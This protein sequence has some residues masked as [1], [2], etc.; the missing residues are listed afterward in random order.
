MPRFMEKS[1]KAAAN[2]KLAHKAQHKI[3]IASKAQ[4]KKMS[5]KKQDDDEDEGL[6]HEGWLR[7]ASIHFSSAEAHPSIPMGQNAAGEDEEYKIDVIFGNHNVDANGEEEDNPCVDDEEVDM[8]SVFRR[9]DS[10]GEEDQT[11]EPVP[12]PDAFYFRLSNNN[13][14]YAENDVS[15]VVL[16]AI[17]IENVIQT[18]DSEVDLSQCFSIVN[19]END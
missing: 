14:Y 19:E 10:Y 17:A 13:L 4:H 6:K 1:G 11:G 15:M 12:A 16:G 7:L 3:K 9:N 18:E 2:H 8:N 5:I